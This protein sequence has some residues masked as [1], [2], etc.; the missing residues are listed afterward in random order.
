MF[1]YSGE[2]HK[3]ENAGLGY[4]ISKDKVIGAIFSEKS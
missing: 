2:I 1:C 4:T 3:F